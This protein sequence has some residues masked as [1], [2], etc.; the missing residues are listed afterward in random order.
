MIELK[1]VSYVYHL[2][3][4][5]GNRIINPVIS[6]LSMTIPGGEFVVLTGSSG[7][8]KTT[9]CRM[10]NGLVPHYFEGELKGK[11]LVDGE[12]VSSQPIYQ[13]AK[14][15]GSVFQNPRSQFF[16]VDTTSEL[17]FTAENQ[18]RN[19]ESILHD[20]KDVTKKLNIETLLDRSMFQLSGGEKQ[21]IACGSVAVADQPGIVLDEPTS[22]LDGS[23]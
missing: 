14:K 3:D 22:N 2:S 5:D 21:K 12:E 11:I 20:I 10:I 6:H 4:T 23:N 7:C 15:V 19:P 9:L 18:G 17:A 8:G 1:D 13:T 16:N